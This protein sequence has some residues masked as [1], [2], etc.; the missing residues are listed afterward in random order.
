MQINERNTVETRDLLFG[1]AEI[2]ILIFVFMLV[3]SETSNFRTEKNMKGE[4]FSGQSKISFQF[5]SFNYN[6]VYSMYLTIL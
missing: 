5:C 1:G 2:F 6:S 4:I 3:W